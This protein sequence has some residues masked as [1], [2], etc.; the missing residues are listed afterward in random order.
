MLYFLQTWLYICQISIF[1]HFLPTNSPCTAHRADDGFTRRQRWQK[2]D[3]NNDGVKDILVLFDAACSIKD[4]KEGDEIQMC[5]RL[6]RRY[7]SIR[8]PTRHSQAGDF[9]ATKKGWN[10]CGSMSDVRPSAYVCHSTSH[11]F[12]I[13]AVSAATLTSTYTFPL[14]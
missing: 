4:R 1:V 13:L 5:R 12:S 8:Q 9:T 7:P 2:I 11:W 3:K 6:R 10:M 14:C